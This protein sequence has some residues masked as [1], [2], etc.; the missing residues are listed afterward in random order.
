MAL[1][2]RS[3]GMPSGHPDPRGHAVLV[4][5]ENWASFTAWT[6]VAGL[7]LD[8]VPVSAAQR[9]RYVLGA[10]EKPRRRDG[11]TLSERELQVLTLASHG[12]TN[13]EIGRHL[14]LSE[15]TIKTHARRLFR[16][17]GVRDRAHAVAVG[18]QRGLLAGGGAP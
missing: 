14:H 17:L 5:A 15:D 2:N 16:K 13:G 11:E 1:V 4:P 9:P 10:P 7:Q 6:K 18:Y 3:N 8:A 12:M